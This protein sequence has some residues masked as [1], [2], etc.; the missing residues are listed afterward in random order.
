[1]E[2]AQ[3]PFCLQLLQTYIG[4][5]DRGTCEFA[6]RMH[7]VVDV[8]MEKLELLNAP[9]ARHE[10]VYALCCA[11]TTRSSHSEILP[12][13]KQDDSYPYSAVFV[14]ALVAEYHD[15]VEHMLEH[16]PVVSCG[17]PPTEVPIAAASTYDFSKPLDAMISLGR[18]AQARMLLSHGAQ[19]EN[20]KSSV[21]FKAAKRGYAD[22]IDLIIDRLPWDFANRNA[23]NTL[24]I[25][26]SLLTIAAT[27]ENW[28]IVRRVLHRPE[29]ALR[30][31]RM[32]MKECWNTLLCSAAN[33]GLND[34]VSDILEFTKPSKAGIFPLGEAASGGQVSTCKLLLR[35]GIVPEGPNLSGRAEELARSVARGGSI[36]ICRLLKEHNLWKPEHEIHFLPVA[37]ECGH[38]EFAKYAIENGC[39][40]KSKPYD[41][42]VLLDMDRPKRYPD[43]IR[44][45][46]L[47]RA[48]VMGRQDIV[49]WLIE[50]LGMDVGKDVELTHP[51]LS[52]V[53]LAVHTNNKD[54]IR[55]LL[56]SHADPSPAACGERCVDCWKGAAQELEKYRNALRLHK[57]YSWKWYATAL[58]YR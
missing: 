23:M 6:K 25:V 3:R 46:A 41:Y 39:D 5:T 24:Y 18:A 19:L 44:Y 28:E 14:V 22:I 54:M 40:M 53:D 15:V 30:G 32:R 17:S 16:H 42:A 48:V 7:W 13:D 29:E 21:Y 36:E 2:Y 11:L 33:R 1:M 56:G 58:G 38:L 35:K 52:P 27:S 47:L 55:L 26:Q 10:V 31:D 49:R 4:E 50:E 34:I 9:K 57:D 43:D 8:L 12:T 20:S 37:A 45:F 51:H